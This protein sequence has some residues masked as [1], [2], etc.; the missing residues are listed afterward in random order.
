MTAVV[1]LV[2]RGPKP[3]CTVCG[4]RRA[5]II[6]GDGPAVC[7]RCVWDAGQMAEGDWVLKRLFGRP[8]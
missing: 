1:N 2:D 6:E 3:R 7:R 5:D 8:Q 4:N